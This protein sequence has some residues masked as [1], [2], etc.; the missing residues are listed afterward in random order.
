LGNTAVAGTSVLR[1]RAGGSC[2]LWPAWK[3]RSMND[4]SRGFKPLSLFNLQDAVCIPRLTIS[5]RSPR[6]LN[7]AAAAAS[8]VGCQDARC[9]VIVVANQI[10]GRHKMRRNSSTM[11][12][13]PRI[14]ACSRAKETWAAAQPRFPPT[15]SS[16]ILCYSTLHASC[17]HSV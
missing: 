17:P 7:A 5:R 6:C 8:H 15:D 13:R 11:L 1:M 14:T 10:E 9:T 12:M 2:T 16:E 4:S 3:L